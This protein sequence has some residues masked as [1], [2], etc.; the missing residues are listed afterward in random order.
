MAGS[1]ECEG[2]RILYLATT[3]NSSWNRNVKQNYPMDGISRCGGVTAV[4]HIG[5]GCAGQAHMAEP[6]SVAESHRSS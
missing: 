5:A 3:A 1:R 2:L 6:G 4:L